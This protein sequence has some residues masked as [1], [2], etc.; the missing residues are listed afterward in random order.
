L[1]LRFSVVKAVIDEIA[2]ALGASTI[3]A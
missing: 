1:A 3:G 2:D